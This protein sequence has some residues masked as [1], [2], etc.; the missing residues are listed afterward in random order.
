MLRSLYIKNYALID[1]FR[2]EF[3]AGLNIVTGETGA[4]KSI[5]LGAFGLLLGDRASAESVRTGTDKTV[6]EAEFDEISSELRELLDANEIALGDA[7]L[8]RREV[9]SKG[10]SRA[11]VND[12]PA[13]VQILKELGE[14]LVDLHGQHEHQS[15]LHV[16]KHIEML[17]AFADLA[18][19]VEQFRVLRNKI[20][21]LRKEIEGMKSRRAKAME[22]HDFFDFQYREIVATDPK[23]GEDSA[24]EARLNILENSEELQTAARE[25][26]EML[27]HG[28]GSTIEK[29]GVVRELLGRFSSID[30]LLMEPLAEAKSALAILTELARTIGN[31][32]SEI[33]LDASELNALR[34]RAQVLQRL[35][36]KFGGSLDAVLGK[37][38]ELEEKLSFE[39]EFQERIT[40]KEKDL[41]LLNPKAAKLASALSK[42]RNAA[43]K[44][45]EPQIV[46]ILK[47][48]GIEHSRFEVEFV[49]E[50]ELN[51]N[52]MDKIEFLI[53][54]NA[55]E[56]P[57]PLARVA[58]GGEISRIM[59]AM[60]TV[61]AKGDK[62][63]LLI[64]DEIDS[65]IS[66]RVAQRVGRAMKAL[67]KEHQTIAITHL[68]QIAACGDEHFLAEKSSSK[69]STSS[70]LLKLS[71]REHIEEVA[72]LISGDALNQ[73]A[74]ANAKELIDEA[75]SESAKQGAKERKV[76]IVA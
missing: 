63:P 75:K 28:E 10:A 50:L 16:S 73:S 76:P 20:H 47:E 21:S 40:E 1:E 68:A 70:R 41:S 33:Q 65:G 26:H 2:V 59:L 53:S 58:S 55:G 57:K 27:Y 35:K 61:L 18:R 14:R 25:M 9:S 74:I 69:G 46:T 67:A 52:G 71:E 36:K 54:T 64:F 42:S 31:Y 7:L 38:R 60:K 3:G 6:V 8:I 48:L 45:L 66:G 5:V 43:A 13:S 39:E 62:L 34:E 37:K 11:F 15:L 23:E 30:P 44:K 19:D 12:S 56:E 32:A 24:I 29:L 51:S 49:D 4:G 22:E 17:D 72:R